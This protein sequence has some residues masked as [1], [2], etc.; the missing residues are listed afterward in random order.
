[1]QCEC[2]TGPGAQISLSHLP[3]EM[4]LPRPR[5]GDEL[6]GGPKDCSHISRSVSGKKGF[7]E[8]FRNILMILVKN[9]NDGGGKAKKQ[10]EP[11]L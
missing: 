8:G 1:M 6:P 2:R 9:G 7:G 5:G 11:P 10:D 3:W 4:L